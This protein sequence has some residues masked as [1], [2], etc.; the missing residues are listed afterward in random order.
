MTDPA[1]L[2]PC[3]CLRNNGGAHRRSCPD[4]KTIERWDGIGQVS[5]SWIPRDKE[6]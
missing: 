6:N 2:W 1:H 3:G 5:R 4:F